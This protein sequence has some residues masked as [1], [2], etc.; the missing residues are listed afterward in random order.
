MCSV[1][2]CLILGDRPTCVVI[3]SLGKSECLASEIS[4]LAVGTFSNTWR[5]LKDQ[6]G[7]LED[8]TESI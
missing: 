6:K 1:A 3:T 4:A 2:K 8:V 7:Y 5:Y